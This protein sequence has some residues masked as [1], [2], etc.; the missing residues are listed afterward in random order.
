MRQGDEEPGPVPLS[1]AIP[2][3]QE[4]LGK[5]IDLTLRHVVSDRAVASDWFPPDAYEFGG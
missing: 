1:P 4:L 5:S 3:L 2:G